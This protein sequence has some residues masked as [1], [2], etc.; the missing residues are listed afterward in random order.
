MKRSPEENPRYLLIKFGDN[1]FYYTMKAFGHVMV[2]AYKEG[3]WAAGFLTKARVVELWNRL[4]PG[5]YVVA[6]NGGRHGDSSPEDLTHT[7]NYLQI[8]EAK[9]FLGDEAKQEAT[10]TTWANSEW[11]WIDFGG[12]FGTPSVIIF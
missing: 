6:Q 12:E 5:L 8:T 2:D 3:S 9:V 10:K 1:D 11:L 4:A 7:A